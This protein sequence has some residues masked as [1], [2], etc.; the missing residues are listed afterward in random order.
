MACAL[1]YEA[2]VLAV[3][4]QTRKIQK[5]SKNMHQNGFLEAKE[6]VSDAITALPPV[7]ISWC[8]S[9]GHF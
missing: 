9:N 3:L 2:T 1:H 8:G 4:K 7:Q 6:L 5:V